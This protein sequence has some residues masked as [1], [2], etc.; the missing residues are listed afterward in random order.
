MTRTFARN[1]KRKPERKRRSL[2]MMNIMILL[3]PRNGRVA[4][5]HEWPRPSLF[6]TL[7]CTHPKDER[8]AAIRGKRNERDSHS[9]GRRARQRSSHYPA[10]PPPS[11]TGRARKC[12]APHLS[13]DAF[14]CAGAMTAVC[15]SSVVRDVCVPAGPRWAQ[16]GRQACGCHLCI[17]VDSPAHATLDQFLDAARARARAVAA[18]AGI[19]G[20]SSLPLS[21]AR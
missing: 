1:R 21:N 5:S 8:D 11:G 20:A 12:S 15:L 3:L 2:R 10:S 17:L 18:R 16:E 9:G 14:F 19:E 13:A 4:S 6:R 7:E